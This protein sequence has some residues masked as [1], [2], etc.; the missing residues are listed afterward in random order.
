MSEPD[1]RRPVGF[2][3]VD[4]D[5]LWTLAGCYGYPEADSFANDPI[6][7]SALARLL[8][9]FREFDIKATFFICGRDLELPEKAEAIAGIVAAGHELACHGYAHRIDLEDLGGPAI[10]EELARAGEAIR[11]VSGAW[12]LGF[13]A[14]GYAAGPRML[15]AVSRAGMRYDGSLL[16]TRW[17]PLLRAMAGRLRARVA[18]ETG[19]KAP[20]APDQYGHGGPLR[21]EWYRP[22]GLA[23]VLRLPVAVSPVLRLPIHASIGMLIGERYVRGGLRGLARRGVPVCYLLH[24]MDALGAE[25]L[26]GRLPAALLSTRAFQIPLENKLAFLRPVLGELNRLTRIQRADRW[27]INQE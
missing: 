9:L 4:L 1:D 3:H 8:Q 7:K 27:L 22:E 2:V 25:E 5:G 21:P 11:A 12:P 26:Q 16:P 15:G 24:G 20:G 14:A 19:C 17:A 13:R 10:D 6:F 18:R 23:P